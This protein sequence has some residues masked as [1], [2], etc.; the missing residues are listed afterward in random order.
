M[1]TATVN[2]PPTTVMEH[3]KWAAV[4]KNIIFADANS[5]CIR[6][7]RDKGCEFFK[8]GSAHFMANQLLLKGQSHAS[9][10]Q[11]AQVF[12]A[13][14]QHAC[15]QYQVSV[16]VQLTLIHQ[17]VV[18]CC[19]T[20]FTVMLMALR[21]LGFMIICISA[22]GAQAQQMVLQPL[23]T[24]RKR[25]ASVTHLDSIDATAPLS[26]LDLTY[27]ERQ[28]QHWCKSLVCEGAVAC[29][30]PHPMNGVEFR[31]GSVAGTTK[32]ASKSANALAV[33]K[34][35]RAAFQQHALSLCLYLQQLGRLFTAQK[36][37]YLNAQTF[38]SG[39]IWCAAVLGSGLVDS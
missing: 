2:P 38:T 19:H 14:L 33:D 18:M 39:T 21:A 16:Q 29:A 13:Q 27:I 7:H 23:S 32:M 35:L 17:P 15:G 31:G 12:H 8:P 34:S 28:L 20:G 6:K 26:L 1:D 3:A 36:S 11:F 9:K 4:G 10:L 25:G 24:K 30:A 37:S 5:D 22:N